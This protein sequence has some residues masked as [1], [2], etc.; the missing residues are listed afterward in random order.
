MPTREAERRE[1][2]AASDA[3]VA[4]RSGVRLGGSLL[5]TWAIAIGIRIL[6]PRQLGP[7]AFGWMNFADAFTATAFVLIAFGI[8]TQIRKEVPVHP[9]MATALFGGVVVLRAGLSLLVLAAM[10]LILQ[11]TRQPG[12]VWRLVFLFGLAQFVMSIGLT[13]SAV[14]HARS[15]VGGLS[16]VN[17]ASKLLWASGVLIGMATPYPLEAVAVAL[18]VAETAKAAATYALARRDVGLR[19]HVDIPA[20]WRSVVIG[21][22]FYLNTIAFTAYGRIDM[23]VLSFSIRDEQQLGWY[24][25]AASLAG[26]SLL[27]TPLVGWVLMPLFVRASARGPE[28]MREAVARSMEV[29]VSIAVPTS[30]ILILGADVWIRLIFGMAYAPAAHQLRVLAAMYVL[31]YVAT[32]SACALNVTGK[33]WFVTR[34]SLTG[35]LVNPFLCVLLVGVAK[36]HFGAWGGAGTGAALAMLGAEAVVVVALTA[37]LGG[38]AFDRRSRRMLLRTF[39]AVAVVVVVHL[40]ARPLGPAR[41]ALDAVAYVVLV[42]ALRAV[43]WRELRDFTRSALR[44]AR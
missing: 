5:L 44:P 22:P 24:G 40:L 7:A 20:A 12:V 19:F 42:L 17:V 27:V 9:E 6:L 33:E 1:E 4:L 35:L 15:V 2:P 21:V 36:N 23:T 38:V 16:M 37:S 11:V 8:D 41:I 18:L 25:A 39:A 26:L 32:V 28:A 14:L 29:V 30:L 43:D 34:I 10:A 3:A 31:T 13:A